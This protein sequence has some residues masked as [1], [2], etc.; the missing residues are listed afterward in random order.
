MEKRR[1]T[2]PTAEITLGRDEILRVVVKPGVHLTRKSALA[3]YEAVRGLVADRRYPLLYDAQGLSSMSRAARRVVTKTAE[4]FS[5]AAA[6][7]VKTPVQRV[8]VAFTLQL[9]DLAFPHRIFSDGEA[10]LAW[11]RQFPGSESE[12]GE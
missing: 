1:A 7:V 9:T 12:D 5:T 4:D 3:T 11:T 2:T 8:V 6:F 10:A